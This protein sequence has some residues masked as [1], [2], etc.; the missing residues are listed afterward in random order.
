MYQTSLHR[1]SSVSSQKLRTVSLLEAGPQSISSAF[2][3]RPAGVSKRL[4]H[5]Q[6]PVTGWSCH[7]STHIITFT[8]P[9][10]LVELLPSPDAPLRL[11]LFLY[12]PFTRTAFLIT[13]YNAPSSSAEIMLSSSM[14]TT[15]NAWHLI[16]CLCLSPVLPPSL[17][18][19]GM[20]LQW[21]MVLPL[22]CAAIAF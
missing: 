15:R 7:Q 16:D 11:L 2:C 14:M 22:I 21:W 18:R 9:K 8:P 13:Y 10:I 17:E 12:V 20:P 19:A 4:E 3:A 5:R 1:I 6:I